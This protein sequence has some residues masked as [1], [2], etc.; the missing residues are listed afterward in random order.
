[1]DRS[2][3]QLLRQTSPEPHREGRLG[4][5]PATDRFQAQ[6]VTAQGQGWAVVPH[7]IGGP[8]SKRVRWG[9]SRQG[10]RSSETHQLQQ[11]QD[12]MGRD[13]QKVPRQVQVAEE[14]GNAPQIPPLKIWPAIH[15][16]GPPR[17][18]SR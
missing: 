7:S 9:R 17:G 1:M 18:L 10:Q 16:A 15:T 14:S 12:R 3:R 6:G 4:T 8:D 13:T 2:G 5:C 11:P